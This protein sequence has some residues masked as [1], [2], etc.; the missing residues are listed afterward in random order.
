M[1]II[2]DK[3]NK[4]L[5]FSGIFSFYLLLIV[6]YLRTHFQMNGQTSL[7]DVWFNGDKFVN[8]NS[9]HIWNLLITYIGNVDQW[10]TYAL[11]CISMK[12]I[13]S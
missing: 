12:H 11:M 6:E 5:F 10:D 2:I 3:L 13:Y 4:L 7:P 9:K 8:R 1:Q